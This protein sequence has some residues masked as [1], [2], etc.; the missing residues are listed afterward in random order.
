MR[1]GYYG[2][3]IAPFGL[4]SDV[5]TYNVGGNHTTKDKISHPDPMAEAIAEDLI[6]SFSRPG[7]LVFNPMAGSGTSLKVALL[8][9]RLFLGMEVHKPYWKE[10]VDRLATYEE[11]Y[12]KQLDDELSPKIVVPS[13]VLPDHNGA[14]KTPSIIIPSKAVGTI[15]HDDVLKVMKDLDDNSFDGAFSNPPYGLKFM[16][17]EWDDTV[18]PIEVWQELL[19]VCKPGA[20]L[21]AFGSPRTHHRLAVQIE[22]AGWVLRDTLQWLH[23]TGMPKSQ[24]ISKAIDRA[25]GA[26][27]E[28]VRYPRRT[29]G[30]FSGNGDPR[31]WAKRSRQNGFHEADGPIPATSDA[32]Q[33]LGYGTALKPAYEPIIVAQKPHEGSYGK[34]ALKWGVAGL[35]IDSSRV[36]GRFPANIILDEEAGRLL[37]M[38][39]PFSKGGKYR[40][41]GQRNIRHKG[42]L[43]YGDGIGGGKQNALDTYGDAGGPSRFFY[44]PKASKRERNAGLEDFPIKRPD[45]RPETAMGMWDTHG[46]QPQQN[47][48]PAVKPLALCRYLAELILPPPR[49]RPAS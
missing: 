42:K 27:R 13:I 6:L 49:K 37:D 38:Q 39:G 48:H 43:L 45:D 36:N 29:G 11:E 2:K 3:H 22:D 31:P 5:W 7:D 33:W 32:A 26:E 44:C 24:D 10:A 18:P 25:L 1:T 20:N 41:S 34:N 23:G 21:L 9:H 14:L 17:K 47:H 30:T 15:K 35:N 46:V 16:G 40:K 28:K 4:R 8:N 19:R 12:K